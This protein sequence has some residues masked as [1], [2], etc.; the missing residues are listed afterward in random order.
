MVLTAADDAAPFLDAFTTCLALVAQWLL[1]T[2][3]IQS[4]YFWI[5][6]D[7]IY[8]PLYLS[9]GLVLT[10]AVYVLFLGLCVAGL[11]SWTRAARERTPV[12]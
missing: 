1:N 12:R 9:K 4:W 6:A 5:V 8:I 10:A 7:C 2:R 3:R 11:R